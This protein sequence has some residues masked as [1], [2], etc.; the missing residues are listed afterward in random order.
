MRQQTATRRR[1]GYTLASVAFLLILAGLVTACRTPATVTSQ[2]DLVTVAPCAQEDGPLADGPVPC[3]WDSETQGNGLRGPY[4]TRWTLYAHRPVPGAHRADRRDVRQPER[5]VGRHQRY[6][7][8]TVGR[9]LEPSN[10]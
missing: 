9:R 10:G 2:L 3:V 1:I 8:V 6:A 4:A 7:T 5:L